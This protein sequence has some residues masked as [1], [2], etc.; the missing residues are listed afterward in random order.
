MR[1]NDSA[2]KVVNI[3]LLPKEEKIEDI[4]AVAEEITNEE[5]S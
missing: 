1:M 3:T 5:K 2:D 4:E